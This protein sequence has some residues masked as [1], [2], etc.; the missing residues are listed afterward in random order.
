MKTIYILIF[1]GAMIVAQGLKAQDVSQSSTTYGVLGGVN[2]FNLVGDESDG[3]AVENDALLGFHGGV[4]VRIPLAN[5]FY[6]QPGLL[7]V[8]K[9]AKNESDLGK[10]TY[11]LAYAELP[12]NF[13]YKAQVGAGSILLG[14]G[15]Y[16]A[17]GINGNVKVES[18]GV[19]LDNDI[20]F[21]NDVALTDP[22]TNFYARRVD[23][24]ANIFF[25]YELAGGLSVQFNAQ[26]GMLDVN[27][28][29][30][31]IADDKTSI[32]NTGFGISLG[33]G[34]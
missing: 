33:Y 11:G 32:R 20:V 5:Q 29:D 30:N 34:F 26:L 1:I 17:Y 16:V 7:Y 3:N 10:I 6:L 9:G 2:Y 28:N 27:P 24:G 25:G 13:L 19:S 12:I 23:A 31:R 14:F 18:G 21:Q 8:Q 4:F 15:P 22:S